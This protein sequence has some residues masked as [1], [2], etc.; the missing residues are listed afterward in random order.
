MRLG[1][2]AENPLEQLALMAGLVPLPLFEAL[3]GL[4]LSRT[5]LV[6][7]KLGVFDA[8]PA[9]GCTAEE[10]AQ[11]L[12]LDARGTR[13]LLLSLAGLKYLKVQKDRFVPSA[14]ARRWMGSEGTFSARDYLLELE[15]LEWGWVSHYE[16]FVRTGKP[17]RIHDG[18]QPA[19]WEL[20]QRGMRNVANVAARE[21][22]SRAP[23]PKRP[24][25]MLDIGGAHGFASVCLC[26][27]YPD[28]QSTILDLPEAVAASGPILAKEGMGD[29]VKHRAGNVLEDDL[30][31]SIYDIVLASNVL[32]HF[33]AQQ[34][35]KVALKVARSLKPGGVFL[36]MDIMNEGMV[37]TSPSFEAVLEL[38]F[39]ATSDSGT[40]SYSEV[41][42][43]Q[44]EAGLRPSRPMKLRTAPGI[45]LQ[46]GRK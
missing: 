16:E 36:V 45:G 32:H 17:L 10:L 12:N 39:A 26:R 8:M 42:R 43:W 33:T 38:F 4:V 23:V 41:Q 19:Q 28:L 44:K 29:R 7:A 34:C 11:T 5:L 31:E 6:A 18:M 15:A 25:R 24:Q 37:G 22:A 2:K 3:V 13:T 30:G 46:A 21:L 1:V 35:E 40:L 9:Q 14:R 27:K 20:Y